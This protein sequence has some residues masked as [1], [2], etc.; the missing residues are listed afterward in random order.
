[1]QEQ[2]KSHLKTLK[3]NVREFVK[4]VQTFRKDYEE[5]GPMVEGINP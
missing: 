1:M 4:E 2:Q 5:D 3:N